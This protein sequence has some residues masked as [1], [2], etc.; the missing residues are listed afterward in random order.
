MSPTFYVYVELNRPVMVYI[1][2][3]GPHK[4]HGGHVLHLHLQLSHLRRAVEQ[5]YEEQTGSPSPPAAVSRPHQALLYSPLTHSSQNVATL[6]RAVEQ[7][8]EEQTG[9][10]SPPAAVSRPHQALLYTTITYSSQNVPTFT[11]C[12]DC[13]TILTRRLNVPADMV[14]PSIAIQLRRAVEQP[15]E[16]R[17]GSPS[18][19]AAV[20][21]PLQALLY[22]HLTYSSQNVA[23]LRRAVEQP[24]EERTGSPSP[25]AAVSR[26]LQA[27]LYRHLTQLRRAVEQPSEER[28]GSPSP[29]AAVSRP[30][31]AL[32][33]RT[34]TYSSQNVPTENKSIIPESTKLCPHTTPPPPPPPPTPT[35]TPTP[36][37]TTN[38][39]GS[40]Q[41]QEICQ[42]FNGTE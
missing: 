10:P 40:T 20:S 4:F 9:S 22:R 34:L 26:P 42:T 21:R 39:H 28:T 32:I 36:T 15:S 29:P 17:T 8:Y 24:S 31:Q 6:R 41:K 37:T 12:P 25:P 3:E 19:P 13:I 2:L 38:T 23:T 7:P 14:V 35:P 16:E 1:K 5:P 27:L 11:E 30:H 18:P 33:Y